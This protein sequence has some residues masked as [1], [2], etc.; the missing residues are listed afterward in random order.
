VRH[1]HRRQKALLPKQSLGCSAVAVKV[2][3]AAVRAV[4]TVV[5]QVVGTAVAVA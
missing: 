5:V 2:T 3:A 1:C 4:A